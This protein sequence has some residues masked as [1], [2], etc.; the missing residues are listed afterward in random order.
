MKRHD[1]RRSDE[2]RP[3]SIT[4]GVYGYAPGSVL[5]SIGNTKILCAV[6]IQSGVPSFL[7]GK[8]KGWL[9]AEYAL[10]PASTHH[11]TTREISAMKRQGRSIEISRIISRA[12]RTVVDLSQLGERTI[13]VDC[14]VLQADGGT[15][16]ASITAACAA[17]RMAQNKWLAD[18]I[19]NAP[20]LADGIAAVS[21]GI[22]QDGHLVLDPDYQ[23][24]CAGHA[25]VNVIMTLSGKL[26]ELQGGAEK[27]PIDWQLIPK[28]GA[29]SQKGIDALSRF[30]TLN[31]SHSINSEERRKAPLFSL[32]NRL[33]R[34][35]TVS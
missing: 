22:M 20:I 28:I 9:T 25:D 3:L 7:R 35:T 8:G 14:D 34:Q 23:E 15:R 18:E 21:V 32:G 4:Y 29:L 30:L 2:L 27:E 31:S 10:L 24:D 19:I 11:R 6:T 13:M 17:L 16:A 33:D 12:L 1:N 5:F 26:I